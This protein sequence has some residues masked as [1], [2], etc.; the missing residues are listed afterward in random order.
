MNDNCASITTGIS[1]LDRVL[2][3]LRWGD[4]VVWQ[5]EDTRD[6][7]YFVKSF[8]NQ[9]NIKSIPLVYIRF[10]EHPPV[11][12]ETVVK[13]YRLD[14]QHGFEAFSSR[15]Y[16]IAAR[17]SPNTCFIFDC[18]SELMFAWA[19]DLM[20]G[21]F[22]RV[23][24]P[25]LF[26]LKHVAYF[27]L[28]RNQNSYH[29]VKRIRNTTQLLLDVYQR[30]EKYY[31]HPLK[32]NG[33]Y[34]P[35]MFM[36][37]AVVGDEAIPITSSYESTSLLARFQCLGN[38]GRKL[39]YWDRVILKAEEMLD[40][41]DRGE[42][43]ARERLNETKEMLCRM[44]IGKDERV[45]ELARQY[46]SLQELLDIRSRLIGTGMIGGKTVGM[47]LARN[48]LRDN[49]DGDGHLFLEPHDSFFV[50]SD[51][52]YTY[53]IENDCW[54]LILE[55]RK[56]DNYF[57]MAAEL[58]QRVLDGILP[59]SIRE[60]FCE[61][62]DYFGQAPII[63]RSSSLLEDNFGHAFAGKYESLFCVNQGD[64]QERC[65]QLERAVKAVYASTLSEEALTYRQQRG[66]AH[67]DEQMAILI[68]RVSGSRRGSYFYPDMAGVALSRNYYAW[69]KELDQNAGM[70]R[71]VVGLGTRAV[72]RSG[73]DYTRMVPLDQPLTRP[74]SAWEDV[75]CF[76]QHQV[77]VLDTAAN[78]LVTVSTDSLAPA[79]PEPEFW[80]MVA[81]EDRE[82]R[83]SPSDSRGTALP[84]WV[85]TFGRVLGETCFPEIIQ[86]MLQTLE[87]AYNHPVDIEFTANFIGGTLTINLL[88]CRPLQTFE[89]S[90]SLPAP[91]INSG[92][93]VFQSSGYF[94]GGSSSQP[95]D[96]IVMVDHAAYSRLPEADKHRTARLIGR[97]NRKFGRD[98]ATVMLIGPGRWGSS[99]PSLGVPVS[100]AEISNFAV[101]VEVAGPGYFPEASFGTHFFQD[102]VENQIRYVALYPGRL[103][104]FFSPRALAARNLLK[105]ILPQEIRFQKVV[106]VMNFA[107]SHKQLWLTT[108][109][110]SGKATC[111]CASVPHVASRVAI[112]VAPSKK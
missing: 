66:L 45:L 5:V 28:L 73:G 98:R 64:P 52:Y 26:Q 88:Q 69:Q 71:L 30:D 43:I 35:T 79:R 23:I 83:H 41:M 11:V 84:R 109:I 16:E 62:M 95:I 77:D 17:E 94:M 60:Q 56:P 104:N 85:L 3:D 13:T 97:L 44:M 36:P 107:D 34:S 20:I 72:A 51:V 47:L 25:Y 91:P 54:D 65:R 74:E 112:S 58:R 9:A 87:K 96:W 100:F 70:M 82:L 63:V 92:S 110:N 46:F 14:P 78:H 93:T 4:N 31:V 75:R 33:R 15:V 57:S 18:L 42:T 12:D 67:C 50:G 106:K 8:V 19:T 105:E 7:Q 102:L 53:L 103:G 99:T 38:A 37:H 89:E 24:C 10:A 1:G 90:K 27:A 108:D 39:D 32:V 111:Y 49:K 76:S 101:I 6:Y 68:Q 59:E 2:N 80:R 22:F 48:I 21:N 61:V 86:K 55:H 81:E 29:T 40:R